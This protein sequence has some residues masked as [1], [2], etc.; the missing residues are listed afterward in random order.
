[1][2]RARE[3]LGRTADSEERRPT[4][5]LTAMRIGDGERSPAAPAPSPQTV[6][7][8]RLEIEAEASG[9]KRKWDNLK[10]KAAG[11]VTALEAELR[12]IGHM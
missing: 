2:L 7:T 11:A 1:M 8:S 10:Q 5:T 3:H 6:V 9:S 4:V 12:A